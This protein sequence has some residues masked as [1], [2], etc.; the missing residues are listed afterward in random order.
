MAEQTPDQEASPARPY[1]RNRRLVDRFFQIRMLRRAGAPLVVSTIAAAVGIVFVTSGDRQFSSSE[2]R[3]A[4]LG[5]LFLVNVIAFAGLTWSLFL[6]SSHLA[7]PLVNL[8]RTLEIVA[9]GDLTARSRVRKDDELQEHANHLNAA[10]GSLQARV[11][12]INQFC[13]YTRSTI[14]DMKKTDPESKQLDRLLELV[15]SIEESIEDFRV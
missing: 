9:K 6:Y 12:R 5:V 2:L 15:K 7:G 3:W 10:I 11:K 13:K 14:E 8:R 1:V 4:V